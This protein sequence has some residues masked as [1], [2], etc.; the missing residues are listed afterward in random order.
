MVRPVIFLNHESQ[1]V[2]SETASLD[3]WA[4]NRLSSQ[5]GEEGGGNFHSRNWFKSLFSLLRWL[6]REQISPIFRR[7]H[8]FHAGGSSGER[9]R[10][11]NELFCLPLAMAERHWPSAVRAINGGE[12]APVLPQDP[13]SR[14]YPATCC[15]CYLLAPF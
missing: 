9:E 4:G 5:R 7:R 12:E 15:T 1:G 3:A 8:S 6:T 11:N 10:L 13:L 2:R 14:K